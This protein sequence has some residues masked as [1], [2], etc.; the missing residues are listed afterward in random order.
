MEYRTDRDLGPY[1]RRANRDWRFWV[2]LV[3]AS[4]AIIIYAMT[5]DLSLVPRR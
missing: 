4:A 5:I 1:W 3:S 2:G